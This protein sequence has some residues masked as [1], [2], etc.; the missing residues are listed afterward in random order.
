LTITAAKK[1]KQK[2]MLLLP[3][4]NMKMDDHKDSPSRHDKRISL[5]ERQKM[6]MMTNKTFLIENKDRVSIENIEKV[7]DLLLMSDKNKN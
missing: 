1:K 6:R 5:I 3:Y 2:N 4:L 7:R